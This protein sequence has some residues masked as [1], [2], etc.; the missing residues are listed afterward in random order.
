LY[1]VDGGAL[2][3]AIRKLAGCGAGG[4]LCRGCGVGGERELGMKNEEAIRHIR[5][6]AI[7]T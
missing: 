1:D 5:L 3:I 4:G 7:E 2:E 6:V